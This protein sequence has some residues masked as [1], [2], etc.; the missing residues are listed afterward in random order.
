M[1]VFKR[2]FILLGLL[3]LMLAGCLWSRAL[4][5]VSTILF[6]AV[7][8]LHSGVLLQ[9]KNAF[10]GILTCSI[11]LLFFIPFIS[12][13]W[14]SDIITW[15]E[16]MLDKLPF[17]FLPIAFSR[18]WKIN[19]D[20]WKLFALMVILFLLVATF[21]STGQYF[22][23]KKMI[24]KSYLQSKLIP[25]PIFG[26][27]IRFSWLVCAGFI[28][29]IFLAEKAGY[30][31]HRIF[32]FAVALWFFVYL[33]LL[34]A[35]TGLIGCYIFI[36]LWG[37]SLLFKKGMKS[38]YSLMLLVLAAIVITAW[39]FFPTLKNRISYMKY[40]LSFITKNEYLPH[41][42]DGN[43]ML[44]LKAG[45]AILKENPL[46]VGAGDVKTEVS[47]WYDTHTK[48]V[49]DQDKIFPSNEWLIHGDTTGWPGALIF[50]IAFFAP[51]FKL[52][53]EEWVFIIGLYM[54]A[55]IACFF[56]SSLEVQPGVFIYSFVTLW[57]SKWVS[58]SH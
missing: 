5:S 18:E 41:S 15:K 22:L 24:D 53:K 4:L 56:D 29:S 3:L 30:T 28:T 38:K 14:S 52:I 27:H 45:W 40:N 16:V 17:L 10:S 46:G 49:S 50:T 58:A 42:N 1:P 11:M 57:W 7:A 8:C 21:W 23:S 55:F 13:L 34:A 48:E 54:A 19:G 39:F 26:D 12:G 47:K 43:R 35:R 31:K 36:F 2:D 9:V 25:V 6:V 44:S 32:Y 37:M 51:L 20:Q 33:H